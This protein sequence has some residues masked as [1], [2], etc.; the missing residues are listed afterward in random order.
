MERTKHLVPLAR[1]R[2]FIHDIYYLNYNLSAAILYSEMQCRVAVLV[3]GLNVILLRKRPASLSLK[4][5][6][7]S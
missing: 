4:R 1:N 2:R 3:V 6:N 5:I 7:K